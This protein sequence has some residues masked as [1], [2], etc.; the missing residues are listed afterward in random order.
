MFQA[1]VGSTSLISLWSLHFA[2][3]AVKVSCRIWIPRCRDSAWSR[4][5]GSSVSLRAAGRG[6]HLGLYHL[7]GA[8]N[9]WQE[10]REGRLDGCGAV[11]IHK[12]SVLQSASLTFG[13]DNSCC[14]GTALCT[15]R[16]WIA[17][18]VSTPWMLAAPPLSELWWAN[19]SPDPA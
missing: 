12:S 1:W 5:P 3:W 18:L 16:G 6:W 4:C 15:E 2:R 11:R 19:V 8:K 14:V 13:A 17:P 9:M 7:L 10:R